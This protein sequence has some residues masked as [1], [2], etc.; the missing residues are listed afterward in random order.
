VLT[1]FVFI[2]DAMRHGE[3]GVVSPFRYAYML[4]ALLMS[5]V[6]FNERPD[7]I[8]WLGIALIIGA[9]L[10]MVHR[11]RVVRSARSGGVQDPA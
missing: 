8:S 7:A 2:I 6:I 5:L 1:G 9:G 3:T 4:F 10:Y 11:E